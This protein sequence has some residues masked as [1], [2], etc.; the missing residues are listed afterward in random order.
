MRQ[1]FFHSGHVTISRRLGRPPGE[2]DTSAVRL[3]PP[4]SPACGIDAR[5]ATTCESKQTECDPLWHTADCVIGGW[6][7]IKQEGLRRFWSMS[8]LSVPFWYP[9]VEPQPNLQDLQERVEPQNLATGIA[10]RAPCGQRTARLFR[11]QDERGHRWPAGP[12]PGTANVAARREER[13]IG[14]N[15]SRDPPNQQR[16]IYVSFCIW[17][18]FVFSW[19]NCRNIQVGSRPKT[20]TCGHKS[21][22]SF[23]GEA[24]QNGAFPF[25]FRSLIN[26]SPETKTNS[27]LMPADLSTWHR[28]VVPRALLQDQAHASRDDVGLELAARQIRSRDSRSAR[29]RKPVPALSLKK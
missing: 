25:G 17:L 11:V 29:R 15:H 7:K 20:K 26:P 1:T 22:G 8:P 6:L 28:E 9:L 21:G 16:K 27:I 14:T 19:P 3:P 12:A 2:R 10:G 23:L 13:K 24:P 5:A 18:N 4:A